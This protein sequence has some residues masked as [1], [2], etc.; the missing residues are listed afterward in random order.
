MARQ[1]TELAREIGD[2]ALRPLDM[3]LDKAAASRGYRTAMYALGKALGLVFC[4]Y[5]T[6]AD[7]SVYI[8]TPAEDADYLARGMID[9]LVDAGAEV[10]FAC[11]WTAPRKDGPL[12]FTKAPLITR[13]YKDPFPEYIDHLIAIRSS[14]ARAY[15]AKFSLDY[16]ADDAN[17]CRSHIIAPVM[18]SSAWHDITENS[19]LDKQA[20]MVWTFAL[21]EDE[22][23][24]LNAGVGGDVYRRLELGPDDM[25]HAL[26]PTI[27]HERLDSRDRLIPSSTAPQ[28]A[29]YVER[30]VRSRKLGSMFGRRA[31][32]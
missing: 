12:A 15:T 2:E 31:D 28:K 8:G 22:G 32:R 17:Y 14:I 1:F 16:F 20:P 29:K 27:V 19:N 26:L 9:T 13:E 18:W 3:L 30:T 23:D 10:R 11:Y 4:K 21:D 5:Q 24:D 7:R 25:R 6:V